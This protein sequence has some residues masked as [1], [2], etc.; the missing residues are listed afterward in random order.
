MFSLKF[1]M[2]ASL[3]IAVFGCNHDDSSFSADGIR[4]EECRETALES[5]RWEAEAQLLRNIRNQD[6]DGAFILWLEPLD[7]PCDQDGLVVCS[8]E[9]MEQRKRDAVAHCDVFLLEELEPGTSREDESK[10]SN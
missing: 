9:S 4:Y 7:V 6:P 2:V 5:L 1:M 8:I 10:L 3:S